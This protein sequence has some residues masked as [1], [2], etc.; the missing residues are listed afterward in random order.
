MPIRG[1]QCWR[2]WESFRFVVVHEAGN[3]AV[4]ASGNIRKALVTGNDTDSVL[5]ALVW[6][7]VDN[8]VAFF[9]LK[10]IISCRRGGFECD[11]LR[12]EVVKNIVGTGV[13]NDAGLSL[14]R[15]FF[16]ERA[17]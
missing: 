6:L 8:S 2:L 9:E 17:C 11:L 4:L 3:A 7:I 5:R 14:Q 16:R 10:V 12:M 15:S 1:D 13:D